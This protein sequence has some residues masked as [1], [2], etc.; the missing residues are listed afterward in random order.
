VDTRLVGTAELTI[1]FRNVSL[2]DRAPAASQ[3]ANLPYA[4]NDVG[5]Q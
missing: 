2:A 3:G 4:I 1:D 5:D